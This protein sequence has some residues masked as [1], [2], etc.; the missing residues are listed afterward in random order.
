VKD[1]RGLCPTGFHVPTDEEWKEL[2][3]TLGGTSVAGTALK[4]TTWG[5]TNS[6]GFSALPGGCRYG[7]GNF[8]R[9]GEYGYWWSSSANGTY[10]WFRYLYSGDL[11]VFQFNNTQRYGYSVRC[12]RD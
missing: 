1:A 7:D 3:G 2:E 8:Y 4:T 5:G 9:Q 12:V 11:N 6:S 10:A